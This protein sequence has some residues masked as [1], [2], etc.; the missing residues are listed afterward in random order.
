M[1]K[2]QYEEIQWYQFDILDT[3]PEIIHGSFLRHGGVSSGPFTSLNVGYD[4]GDEATNV[5]KNRQRI[6]EALGGEFNLHDAVQVHGTTVQTITGISPEIIPE[7]DALMTNVPGHALMIK[8]ADCQAAIF[9]D[10]K[11]KAIAAVHSGWRGSIQNIYKQT[12]QAMTKRYN[13]E[14]SDLIVGIGPS[15]G[16]SA[17][18]FTNYKLELPEVLWDF[19]IDDTHFDFWEIARSQ[20]RDC[21]VMPDNVEVASI[22]THDN[23]EDF[24]SYRREKTTGRHATLVAISSS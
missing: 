20:L 6:T 7:C 14:P 18:E 10:P 3:Y 9:Y 17:S 12:I 19:R 5:A 22:C 16:P 11:N 24:F 15:L 1:K 8:H 13:T 21:G 4:L 2:Q 23:P